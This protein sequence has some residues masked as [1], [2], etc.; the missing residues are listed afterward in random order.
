MSKNLIIIGLVFIVAVSCK[1]KGKINY[2]SGDRYEG[3]IRG[4]KPHGK[5][6]YISKDG[7]M[8]IGDF[9]DGK[10]NGHGILNWTSGLHEGEQYIGEWKDDQKSGH[11]IFTWPDG[12]KYVGKWENNRH[13]G[14]GTLTNSRGDRYTGHFKE[15]LPDGEGTQTDSTGKVIFRGNWKAGVPVK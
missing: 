13:N 12:R 2:E 4:N 7:I 10:R 1:H 9:K 6:T 11:G 8:Y 3:E 15:D 5:G 14:L